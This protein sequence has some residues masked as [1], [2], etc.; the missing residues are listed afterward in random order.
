MSWLPVIPEI[1]RF[2]TY[3]FK[4]VLALAGYNDSAENFEEIS[5][6]FWNR[7]YLIA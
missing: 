7:Q 5:N 6:H 3:E 1:S 4:I 2:F